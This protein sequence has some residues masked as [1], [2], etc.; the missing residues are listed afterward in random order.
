MKKDV[1]QTDTEDE[2]REAK[3][4]VRLKAMIKAAEAGNFVLPNRDPNKP[5]KD[6]NYDD[7]PDDIT[8]YASTPLG[9]N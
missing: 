9:D 3:A 2:S 5:R 6:V 4:V 8:V 7:I 1:N